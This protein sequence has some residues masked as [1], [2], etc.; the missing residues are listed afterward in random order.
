LG[1]A[2]KGPTPVDAISENPNLRQLEPELKWIS[3]EANAMQSTAYILPAQ[4]Y[5][6]CYIPSC[7]RGFCQYLIIT[8]IARQLLR[9]LNNCLDY[10]LFND[11]S[12][13]AWITCHR[14]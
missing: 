14:K 1:D 13:I 2:S 6:D 12:M 10:S 7:P 9:L 8:Q 3:L 4:T 5:L 11:Y